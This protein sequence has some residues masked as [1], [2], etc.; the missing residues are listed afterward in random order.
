V[1][2]MVDYAL[3]FNVALDSLPAV[4]RHAIEVL[5]ARND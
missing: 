5:F 2:E 3:A 4:R 1:V